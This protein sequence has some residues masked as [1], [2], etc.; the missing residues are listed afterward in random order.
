MKMGSFL[1]GILG[2]C[3]LTACATAVSQTPHIS[4]QEL[5]EEQQTQDAIVKQNGVKKTTKQTTADRAAMLAEI[6]AAGA[7]VAK[8]GR[9]ICADMFGA[10]QDCSFPFALDEANVTEVNAYTDGSKIVVSPAMVDFAENR[11]QLAV[12]LS[13]EYAHA[14]MTHPAKAQ[15][16]ATVGGLLGMAADALAQSQGFNTSGAFGKIAT[17][18]SVLRYSQDFEREADYIGMYILARA[19]YPV[20]EAAKLWR[21]M[22]TVNPE[23]VYNSSTHPTSAERYILLSKTAAEIKQKQQ[24]HQPLLP[25]KL[26]E[27]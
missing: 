8:A 21:R 12:V 16:N 27:Q 15:Q 24:A 13:H 11:E 22:A 25:E 19:G 7:P 10:G 18:V 5:A 2:A 17:Q 3:L 14:V 1:V 20:Q 6:K 23:G 4:G 9:E 26:P